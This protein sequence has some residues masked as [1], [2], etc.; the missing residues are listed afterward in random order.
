MLLKAGK[1]QVLM[2]QYS[3]HQSPC[4]HVGNLVLLAVNEFDTIAREGAED[5]QANFKE[6]RDRS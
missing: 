2:I 5:G 1:R 3:V 4:R 6:R